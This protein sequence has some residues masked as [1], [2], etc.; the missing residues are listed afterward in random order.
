MQISLCVSLVIDHQQDACSTVVGVEG[1]HATE[2]EGE[3]AIDV[4]CHLAWH[5]AKATPAANCV[6]DNNSKSDTI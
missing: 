3:H 2:V 1:E 5:A 4:A 6:A